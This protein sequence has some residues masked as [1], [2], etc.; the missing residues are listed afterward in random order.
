M[1]NNLQRCSDEDYLKIY[2]N[3]GAL[4]YNQTRDFAHLSLKIYY[5]PQSIANLLSLKEVSEIK[6][7]RMSMDTDEDPSIRLHHG[8]ITLKFPHSDNGLYYC[9]V[10]DMNLFSSKVK[11]V[12]RPSGRPTK[13]DK[14]VSFLQAHTKADTAKAT[15][16]RVLQQQMMWPSDEAMK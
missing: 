14:H 11:S 5:N 12:G 3:G 15:Q 9:T 7:Y 8:N 4:E 2:T 10:E 13:A 6:G 1:V 16:A